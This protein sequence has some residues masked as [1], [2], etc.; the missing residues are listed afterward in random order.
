MTARQGTASVS[1]I[2]ARKASVQ[3]DG[4]TASAAPRTKD[5]Q[6]NS[7]L[8]LLW[9]EWFRRADANQRA[10]ML[11]LAKRQGLLYAHQL[12]ALANG[13][14]AFAATEHPFIS[15][16][17]LL[18]G[19]AE[20]LLAFDC[21]QVTL[22]DA[23]LDPLQQEAVARAL[24]T[25][26]V[27]LLTGF[28]GAGKSRVLAEIALQAALQ[29][30]RVLLLAEV[31]TAVDAV[32]ER[33]LGREAVFALRFFAPSES[34]TSLLPNLRAW[35]L[36][37]R[38][39]QLCA[40]AS[41]YAA[42]GVEEAEARCRRRREEESAWLPLAELS[43][44]HVRLEETEQAAAEAVEQ[45]PA[46]L[47]RQ[48]A[49]NE[50]PAPGW[51]VELRDME[52]AWHRAQ[53]QLEARLAEGEASRLSFLEAIRSTQLRIEE[54]RPLYDA[55]SHGHWWTL[56]WW[57]ATLRGNVES[58]M[59]SLESDYQTATAQLTALDESRHKLEAEAIEL[60][61][62]RRIEHDRCVAVELK[63]RREAERRRRE[64]HSEE[65][66]WLLSEW[67][68]ACAIL[69]D[70]GDRPDTPTPA[71]VEQALGRWQAHLQHDEEALQFA[72]N[73]AESG[74]AAVAELSS[75]LPEMAN[76]LA[77]P[78]GALANDAHLAEALKAPVDLLILEDADRFSEADLLKLARYAP[79]CVLVASALDTADAEAPPPGQ[80]KTITTPAALR[81][82]GFAKLWKTLHADM[83]R[84]PYAWFREGDRLGCRLRDILVPERGQFETEH[85]ADFPEIELRIWAPPKVL[86]VLAQVIFPAHMGIDQA[87]AFLYRELQEATVQGVGRSC[88]LCD[89]G[90]SLVFRF[91]PSPLANA[92][93][94]ELEEGLC[95]WAD[96][97]NGR[98]C[99][100]EFDGALWPRQR[101]EQWLRENLRGRDMGRTIFLETPYRQQGAWARTLSDIVFGEETDRVLASSDELMGLTFVPV[102]P[103]PKELSRRP[104]DTKKNGTATNGLARLP[105]E[106]AGLEQDLAQNRIADRLPAELRPLLPGKGF[107]NYLEAQALLRTLEDWGVKSDAGA[108]A[109]IALAD[110][111]VELLRMLAARSPALG[112]LPLVFASPGQLRHREFDTTFVSLTRSHSHRAVP[113]CAWAG[114][115]VLALTRA[116]RRLFVFG[117]PGAL[118]RRGNW[119]GPL[120]HLDAHAAAQE[121]RLC[122]ALVRYLQGQGAFSA[123]FRLAESI[124]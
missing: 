13:A 85:V 74:A 121:T 104:N 21:P 25:P 63:R 54:L 65:R 111:Q 89:Q 35:T 9:V 27:F 29:G 66:R 31:P 105:K 11:S 123:G 42:K 46:E 37:E 99:R 34:A 79:R 88:W 28:P 108:I 97:T 53:A 76:L 95:E 78:V 41:V 115:L 30:Q 18:A 90:G 103:V 14:K 73:W 82:G 51:L 68:R 81:Q 15:L 110:P 43:R 113:Y 24:S 62:Q 120:E 12:P 84:L 86:P 92:C 40:D 101:V 67:Q 55:K 50:T 38:Q 57:R 33:L 80:A 47:E 112:R 71:A 48:A 114:D 56:R 44:N 7:Q 60:D 26:D 32:L 16:T 58:L 106:G 23:E 77:G 87:K 45:L 36:P 96:P 83:R 109:V 8:S 75:R 98:T 69:E 94:I 122:A 116:R 52:L 2:A 1:A 61:G 64:A 100:L 5:S 102:P 39:R 22:V 19:Q 17:K 124:K 59:Q 93:R 10:Q 119:K 91:A 4:T 117:D 49:S 72:R 20:D 70:T 6:A 107:V 118:V 3:A